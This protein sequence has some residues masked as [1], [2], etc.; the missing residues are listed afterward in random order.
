MELFVE[1]R[2][3]ADKALIPV[4]DREINECYEPCE[5][6]PTL[7]RP[8]NPPAGSSATTGTEPQS[9]RKLRRSEPAD[10]GHLVTS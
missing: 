6:V 5:R 4:P 9:S 1:A 7:S 3:K 8:A 10:R 2:T